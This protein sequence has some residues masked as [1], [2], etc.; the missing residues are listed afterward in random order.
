M[1]FSETNQKFMET[2]AL[3][4]N[5]SRSLQTISWVW[6]GFTTDIYM[7][8]ILREHD[9]LDYLTLNLHKLKPYFVEAFLD[10]GWQ[11]KNL[12]NGDLKFKK[13]SIKVQLGNIEFGER[14]RWT[15]NGGNGSLLFPVSWLSSNVVEFAGIKLHVIAPELQYVLKEHPELLNPAWLMREKDIFDKEYLRDFLLKRQVDVCSLHKFVSSI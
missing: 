5:I 7:G 2:I 6:G 11:V 1:P 10:C 13:D 15:H 9:D 14:A 3:V 12:E 8:Q 4:E